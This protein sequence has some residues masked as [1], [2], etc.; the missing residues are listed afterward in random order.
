LGA[1]IEEAGNKAKEAR[2]GMEGMGKSTEKLEFGKVITGIASVGMSVTRLV[3][4]ISSAVG[5]F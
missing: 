3:T 4:S 1:Q 5:A 2:T